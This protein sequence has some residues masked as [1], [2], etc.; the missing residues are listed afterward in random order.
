MSGACSTHEKV[1]KYSILVG[2]PEGERP[3]KGLCID[4]TI[5]F[6]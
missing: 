3:L 1:G 4:G 2:K 6:E 5:T